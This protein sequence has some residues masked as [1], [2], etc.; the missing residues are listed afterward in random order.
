MTITDEDLKLIDKLDSIMQ[1]GYYADGKEVT[2]IYNRVFEQRL[3]PTNCS[4]CLRHRI[5]KL[6][7]AK[8]TYLAQLE[9]T[10]KQQ[11]ETQITEEKR[12]E[13]NGTNDRSGSKP[14]RKESSK[15]KSA[16]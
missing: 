13:N 7:Q 11:A 15:K 6:A 12:V 3:T 2:E 4:S 8:R 9:A 10:S 1:R 14:K 16:N 5:S